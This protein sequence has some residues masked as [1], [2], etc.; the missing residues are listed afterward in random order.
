MDY[1]LPIKIPPELEGIKISEHVGQLSHVLTDKERRTM[2]LVIDPHRVLCG[3]CG[4]P[5]GS[6]LRFNIDTDELPQ[7]YSLDGVTY[8]RPVSA[9][10][11]PDLMG[12]DGEIDEA[13]VAQWRLA[14]EI[15]R[16]GDGG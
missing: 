16:R 4:Q 8:N 2:V 14:Q 9:S 6:H 1:S 11:M 15:L 10:E 3:V 13:K 5:I 12:P 7:S